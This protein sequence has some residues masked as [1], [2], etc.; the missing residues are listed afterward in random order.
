MLPQLGVRA[1]VFLIGFGL[2][3]C[4]GTS[5]VEGPDTRAVLEEVKE[6]FVQYRAARK[7][8]PAGLADL[9]VFA[10]LAPSGLAALE[11][12]QLIAVWGA[13]LAQGASQTVLVYENSAPQNGGNVLM[14]DG[15]IRRMTAQEFQAAPKAKN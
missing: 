7:R 1:V 11:S 4:G 3:G 13:G 9:Q 15:T 8:A 14:Q 2:A 10:A 6:L 5:S 12:G